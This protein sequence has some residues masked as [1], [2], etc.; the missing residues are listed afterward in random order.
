MQVEPLVKFVGEGTYC[1]TIRPS[2]IVTNPNQK[3]AKNDVKKLEIRSCESHGFVAE[4]C[5]PLWA[6]VA[7]VGSSNAYTTVDPLYNFLTLLFL[8]HATACFAAMQQPISQRDDPSNL[9]SHVLPLTT[10]IIKNVT[11]IT[12]LHAAFCKFTFS[13]PHPHVSHF[14]SHPQHPSAEAQS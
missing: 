8:S 4:S 2:G 5:S 3:C 12:L 11:P 9:C 10:I 1:F 6:D 13:S 14:S 7:P